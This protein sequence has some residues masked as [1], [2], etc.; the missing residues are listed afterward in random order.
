MCGYNNHNAEELYVAYILK[1]IVGED[2]CAVSAELAT[3]KPGYI[4]TGASVTVKNCYWWC[5]YS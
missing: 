3:P 1:L 2:H 5:F 4:P